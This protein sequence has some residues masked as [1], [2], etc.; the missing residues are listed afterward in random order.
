MQKKFEKVD[1][2]FESNKPL[3]Q[4]HFDR[5]FYSFLELYEVL[6]SN[7]GNYSGQVSR[8]AK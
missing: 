8:Q 3:V 7:T 2:V 1:F 6:I 5:R 4:I